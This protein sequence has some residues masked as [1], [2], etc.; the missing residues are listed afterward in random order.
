[1]GMSLSDQERTFL[2][3]RAKLTRSWPV[4]GCAL[5][6]LL[7]GL[8][9]WLFLTRPFMANPFFVLSN[10][11][12]AALPESDAILIMAMLPIVFLMC[13]FLAISVV[14]FAFAAFRNEKKHIAIIKRLV[15]HSEPK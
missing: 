2:D 7:I 6:C 10:L 15:E 5:L 13:M 1:M 11:T 9:V 3:R 14:L 8:T 12:N 4:V